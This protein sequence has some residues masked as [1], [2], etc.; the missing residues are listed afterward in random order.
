M[1]HCS[2]GTPSWWFTGGFLFLRSVVFVSTGLDKFPKALAINITY[3]IYHN[4]HNVCAHH[5][6]HLAGG[7]SSSLFLVF[8]TVLFKQRFCHGVEVPLS[9]LTDL[10]HFLS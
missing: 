2:T 3:L 10:G 1:D 7:N 5:T 9:D 8:G 4:L 6:E